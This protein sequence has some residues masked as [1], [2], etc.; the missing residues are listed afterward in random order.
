M[1]KVSVLTKDQT[2][3]SREVE[4]GNLTEEQAKYDARRSVLLQ[5][6]GASD[7]IYPDI[8]IGNTKRM[9]CICYVVMVLG[10]R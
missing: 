2:V 10:T 4:L 5:C 1:D 6:I 8:F 9:P 7:Y 3:V